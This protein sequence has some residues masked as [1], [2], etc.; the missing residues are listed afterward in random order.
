[1]LGEEW[2]DTAY[3]AHKI[4]LRGNCTML[5]GHIETPEDIVDHIIKL[6]E[7]NK[8]TGGFTDIYSPKI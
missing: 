5:F 3:Q 1:M 7:L 6:R 8:K 2:L 4:G